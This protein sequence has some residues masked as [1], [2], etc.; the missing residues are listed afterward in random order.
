MKN[1]KTRILSFI[2]ILVL[3]VSTL[4]IPSSAAD[5]QPSSYSRSSN[6]GKRDVVA[7]T[8]NGTSAD[9]YYTGSYTYDNL[10][11]LSSTSLQQQLKTL[12]TQTHKYTSTYDDCHYKAD[13][14]DCEENN[15]KVLL[16]YTSYS[17]TM[18]QWNGW[19]REH[20]WPK[21]LGGD[22]TTGG[23]ADLHHIRPSDAG[24]NSSRGN[25]KYGEAGSG[26]SSKTGTDPAV[27]VLGGYYNSTYFEPLD[28]V[29]GDVARI[30]L[31]VWIRWGSAWGAESVTEVFQSVDILLEWCELDP[32]DTW[33]LGRNEV[34]QGIQGNRN[35]FI[36]YPELA[37]LVFGREV[38]SDMQTPSGEAAG[39]SGSTSCAHTRTEIR[40]KVDATCQAGGYT[41]DTYCLDCGRKVATGTSTSKL[42]KHS[43]GEWEYNYD[44]N[45]KIR[46]CIYGCGT[47]QKGTFTP[48]GDCTHTSR[49]TKNATAATCTAA[50][51][52][53]DVYCSSCNVKLSSGTTVPAT[54]HTW[55]AWQENPAE[56]NKT[57]TCQTCGEVETVTTGTPDCA[58]TATELRGVV[59]A[60]CA[61]AGYTGDTY[62]I[63]CG[64]KT[65]TGQVISATGN[66]TFGEVTVT[67]APTQNSDGEGTRTCSGCGTVEKV[68]LPATSAPTGTPWLVQVVSAYG[69]DEEKIVV[70]M[71]WNAIYSFVTSLMTRG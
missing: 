39:G 23:G 25:K 12:M 69:K 20:V 47:S 14:T 9:D 30:C 15:G 5:G 26:A 16:I 49:T 44:D 42:T 33:E 51:Y 59:A 11:Q 68:V 18:S 19:N 67:V 65:A 40:G 62:C 46:Y 7:T 3:L 63:D 8:L 60:T 38:P 1:L 36:D 41:G 32:V 55:S 31:Y 24:V 56:G 2:L 4:V 17:A 53:G 52:S 54:G 57:R 43:W 50:G 37:W 35:V 6:S 58:H 28:N 13:K 21:S 61:T 71:S 29:K 10:S 48:T 45:T 22:T 64:E 34:I 70:L 66:H 27:G